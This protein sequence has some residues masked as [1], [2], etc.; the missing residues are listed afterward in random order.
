MTKNRTLFYLLLINAP[1]YPLIGSLLIITAVLWILNYFFICYSIIINF[2]FCY[3]IKVVT[4]SKLTIQIVII[5]SSLLSPVSCLLSSVSDPY[6]ASRLDNDLY[7]L[8]NNVTRYSTW[9]GGPNWERHVI[10]RRKLQ[11][12]TL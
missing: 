4:E 1:F 12:S 11:N 10:K 7:I 6:P 5:V 2:L 8:I 3:C 9:I